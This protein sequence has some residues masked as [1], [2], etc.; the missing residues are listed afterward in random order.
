MINYIRLSLAVVLGSSWAYAASATATL[1][2]TAPGSS[3]QGVATL[4]DVMDGVRLV[5]QASG[6]PPGLHAFH[7]HEFGSCADSAMAAGSHYNPKGTLHGNVLEAGSDKAHGGDMGNLKA[8]AKGFAQ[9]D[10]TLPGVV[11]SGK[12]ASLAGRALV[13]HE[14]EDDFSQ[15]AGN[16]G[17]RIACGPIVLVAPPSPSK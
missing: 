14:K 8:D 7:I 17:G 10:V 4:T 6:L 5:F 11:L 9:V 1:K 13:I 15:P 2:A 16:A 3:M 12:E